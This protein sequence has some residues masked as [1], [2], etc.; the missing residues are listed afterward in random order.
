M[1]M[2]V[3]A[4]WRAASPQDTAALAAC[5]VGIVAI[6]AVFVVGGLSR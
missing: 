5:L 2:R 3:A 1:A 4:W 6:G